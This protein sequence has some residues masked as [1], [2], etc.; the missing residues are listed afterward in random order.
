MTT[1]QARAIIGNRARWELL[2]IARAL[3]RLQIL[4]TPEENQRLKAVRIL[5]KAKQ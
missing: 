5:L 4:N 3:S 2:A 1:D